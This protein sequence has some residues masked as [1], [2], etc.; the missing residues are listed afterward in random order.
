M[1]QFVSITIPLATLSLVVFAANLSAAPVYPVDSGSIT[2]VNSILGAGLTDNF[3]F[4]GPLVS[5][6]GSGATAVAYSTLQSLGVPFPFSLNLDIDDTGDESG[7]AIANGINYPSVQYPNSATAA[8][9]ALTNVTITAGHLTVSVPADVTGEIDVCSPSSVCAFGGGTP[10]FPFDVTLNVPGTL[11]LTFEQFNGG[12]TYDLT[13]AQ[14]TSVPEPRS[15]W[16]CVLGGLTLFVA[17]R[18]NIPR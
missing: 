15:S 9:T 10:T 4:T 17:G 18:R 13:K 3:H 8:V 12:A 1:N 5:I 16:I 2:Y 11:T 7:P 14:F 6:T